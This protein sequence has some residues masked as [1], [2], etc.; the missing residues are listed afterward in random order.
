MEFLS[1]LNFWNLVIATLALG[2]TVFSIRLFLKDR[3][4][5]GYWID[6]STSLVTIRKGTESDIKIFYKDETEALQD[7]RIIGIRFKNT[8]RQSIKSSDFESPLTLTFDEGVRIIS[9]ESEAISPEGLQINHN[10][11]QG[12]QITIEP[13]LLN[14]KDRFYK[15]NGDEFI[16]KILGEG[17]NDPSIQGRIDGVKDIENMTK[18]QDFI[19]L[20]LIGFPALI[21]LCVLATSLFYQPTNLPEP[22]DPSTHRD[23]I[24]AIIAL[25]GSLMGIILS[26]SIFS[27]KRRK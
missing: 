14:A 9:V 18:K 5:L 6:Y 25:S 8:G 4:G 13:L 2:A 19:H 12:N 7:A 15:D 23:T 24:T 11:Q 1:N 21:I 26:A 20:F 10:I 3:K 16:L 17:V 27:A 22:A